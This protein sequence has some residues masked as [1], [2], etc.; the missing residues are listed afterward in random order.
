ML[1]A[2][3]AFNAA[4]ETVNQNYGTQY[5]PHAISGV[6]TTE[7]ANRAERDIANLLNIL[8]PYRT[9]REEWPYVQYNISGSTDVPVAIYGDSF[10]DQLRWA[11]LDSGFTNKF[12]C[13]YSENSVPNYEV[14]ADII[15]NKKIFLM[16]WSDFNL[17]LQVMR[18]EKEIEKIF[19]IIKKIKIIGTTREDKTEWLLG[20]SE[21]RFINYNSEGKKLS[22]KIFGK[23]PTAKEI[24]VSLNGKSMLSISVEGMTFPAHQEIFLPAEALIRG[25]NVVGLSVD[26]P[27]T[28]RA[29]G[30]STD[31]RLLGVAVRDIALS[32]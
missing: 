4:V 27:A 1:G 14:M 21:V 7:S 22:F 10:S 12:I 29:L 2:S 11:A 19:S 24:F 23:V 25:E 16:V 18:V 31:S 26:K 6:A 30:L 17:S 13:S 15:K 9:E 28:P 8:P 32:Q 3:V 5:R 20:F